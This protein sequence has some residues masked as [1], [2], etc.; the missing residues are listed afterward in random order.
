MIKIESISKKFKLYRS[1]FDRFKEILLWKSYH[2]EFHA[3]R[4]VSFEVADGEAMGIIGQNGAGK[5]TLLKI[6]NGIYLPDSGSIHINGK[7]TGLLELG[8][9]FNMEMTGIENIYM[10]GLLLGM[11]RDEIDRKKN[12]I[13]EFTELGEFIFEPI[14]TYSSGMTMRLA[15]S[16]A[17]HADPRCFVIDEALSVGDAHFQQK[18]MRRIEDFREKGGSIIFVSHD[19]NAVKMLCDRALLLDHGVIVEEGEPENVVNAYNFIIARM[20]DDG[21]TA[22]S[23]D[24][25]ESSYGTYEAKITGIEITGEKSR[26]NMITSGEKATISIE[27]EAFKDLKNITVGIAIRDKFGQDI[28]G[29][30]TSFHD[31]LLD[32]VKGKKYLCNF[33]ADMNIAPGKY[34]ITAALH[35]G[36][37][38]T[39]HC[40]FWKDKFID[41]EISGIRGGQFVGVC[42]L[43]PEIVIETKKS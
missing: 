39:E 8:T 26:S 10:N 42:R 38:H 17:I 33:T 24:H 31:R 29:T 16:I 27:I 41:F 4:D 23:G 32:I 6:L 36:K 18:C 19:L 43:V 14:K 28:F 9:G 1:P 11:S 35:V 25:C 37:S 2:T 22:A 13:I 7:I 15:F 12:A 40:V 3:L 34:S 30:N 20:T 5:S 21:A